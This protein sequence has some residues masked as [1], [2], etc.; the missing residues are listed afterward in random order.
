VQNIPDRLFAVWAL[1]STYAEVV[2]VWRRGAV[3]K[4][5]VFD[6]W[7]FSDLRLIDLWLTF[8]NFVG[9]VSAAG[10]PTRPTQPSNL[11]GSVNE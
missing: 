9:K 10:Q 8:D 1:E 7:T 2:S 4:T 6:W 11:S 5:S 3:V